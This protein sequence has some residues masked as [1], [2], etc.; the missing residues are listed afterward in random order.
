MQSSPWIQAA[1]PMA[2]ANIA[3]PLGFGQ[4]VAFG[5]TGQ[6]SLA[7]CAAVFVF[8]VLDQLYIVF[9][10]DVSDYASDKE[11]ESYNRFSGGS[12]VLGDGRLQ[13]AELMR[14][15]ITSAVL[16]MVVCTMLAVRVPSPSGFE[17]AGDV[18]LLKQAMLHDPLVGAVCDPN[19]VWQMADEMLVAQSQWLPQ[20]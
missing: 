4:A 15:A 1:R 12:R 3:I 14:A 13:P 11:N 18:T 19:E 10:N 6:F 17:L 7:V 9:A 2:Q 8:G 16:M 5:L 20:K